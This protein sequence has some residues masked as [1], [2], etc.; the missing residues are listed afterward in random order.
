M[1]MIFQDKK[2]EVEFDAAL[3]SS[4]TKYRRPNTEDF[5]LVMTIRGRNGPAS[6]IKQLAAVLGTTPIA[7]RFWHPVSIESSLA[8][9]HGQQ[10]AGSRQHD[11]RKERVGR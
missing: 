2:E 6:R 9:P 1:K 10:R 11:S 5:A 4:R 7:H 3:A 8:L